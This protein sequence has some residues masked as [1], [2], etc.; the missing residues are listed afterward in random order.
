MAIVNVDGV[1][2][3]VLSPRLHEIMSGTIPKISDPEPVAVVKVPEGALKIEPV[4]EE[5]KEEVAKQTETATDAEKVAEVKEAQISKH[6]PILDKLANN[7]GM[8]E[9]S[10]AL[11]HYNGLLDI[12]EY[13]VVPPLN[14]IGFRGEGELQYRWDCK[15]YPVIEKDLKIVLGEESVGEFKATTAEIDI[16][17][18]IAANNSSEE[19]TKIIG[20]VQL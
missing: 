20:F 16:N 11:K 5:K 6:K 1:N 7:G 9:V 4:I 19:A 13:L 17:V 8:V 3:V 14:P 12:G 15:L 10:G 18:A 2:K